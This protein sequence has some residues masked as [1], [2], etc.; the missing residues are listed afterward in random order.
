MG[1]EFDYTLAERSRDVVAGLYKPFYIEAPV[2]TLDVSV[3]TLATGVIPV[4]VQV[5]DPGGDPVA[6]QQVIQVFLA[7][8]EAGAT[9][10]T[11]GTQALSVA[12]DGAG[13]I[14]ETVNA[15]TQYTFATDANGTLN[16]ELAFSGAD[17]FYLVFVLPNGEIQVSPALTF[18]T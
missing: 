3:G 5:Q 7:E 1:S 18:T 2:E 11:S 13:Q 4:D 15:G 14:L 12:T 8:D 10:F 17:D 6:K 9:L 16:L